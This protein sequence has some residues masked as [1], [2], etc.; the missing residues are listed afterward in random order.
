MQAADVVGMGLLQSGRPFRPLGAPS[1]DIGGSGRPT[2]GG[3]SE[4]R[5]ETLGESISRLTQP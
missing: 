5:G 2:P 3:A 4:F 1:P